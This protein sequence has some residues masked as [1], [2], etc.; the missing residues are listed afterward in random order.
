[1]AD[2]RKARCYHN[3]IEYCQKRKGWFCVRCGK[4]NKSQDA[5]RSKVM[6]QTTETLHHRLAMDLQEALRACGSVGSSI[7]Y[8]ERHADVMRFQA[9]DAAKGL[10]RAAAAIRRDVANDE[11]RE[12]S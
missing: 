5:P 8:P 6:A 12:S 3:C 4:Q 10:E 7:G 11:A 9:L 2:G 1:M